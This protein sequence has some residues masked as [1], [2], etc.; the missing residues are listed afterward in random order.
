MLQAVSFLLPL[1]RLTGRDV[2]PMEWIYAALTNHWQL[3]PDYP[4]RRARMGG[5]FNLFLS[6]IALST[7]YFF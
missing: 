7:F 5:N 1:S 2:N 6:N 4:P 3:G